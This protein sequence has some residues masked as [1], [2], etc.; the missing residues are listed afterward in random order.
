V[1]VPL[2]I[3]ETGLFRGHLLRAVA[4]F[5][6][7]DDPGFLPESSIE[8]SMQPLR[9]FLRDHPHSAWSKWYAAESFEEPPQGI[10]VG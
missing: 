10:L 4:V 2:N 6:G 1:V 9:A 5:E 3:A 7:G 8:L